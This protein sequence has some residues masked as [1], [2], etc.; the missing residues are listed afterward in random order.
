MSAFALPDDLVCDNCGEPVTSD[1]EIGN[2]DFIHVHVRR[3]SCG[4]DEPAM[5]AG[6]RKVAA[7]AE[8]TAA[9]RAVGP[10]DPGADPAP[11]V[12]PLDAAWIVS[13]MEWAVNAGIEI[14]ITLT[15]GRRTS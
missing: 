3:Y 2:E 7:W 1:D 14:T 11:V 12:N 8:R 9:E 15:T 6:F 5:V 10:N 4:L 13:M